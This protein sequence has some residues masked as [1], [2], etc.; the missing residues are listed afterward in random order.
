[1]RIVLAGGGS[2]GST[3]PLLA[4]AEALRR[5]HEDVEFLYIGSET[6]PERALVEK[7]GIRFASIKTGKLRRYWSWQNFLD[8]FRTGIGLMQ[9]FQIIREFQPDALT[10]A[11]GFICVP[12]ALAAWAL[13][14][15]VH[16]HQQDVQ[17]GLANKIISPFA[18]R[19][20]VTFEESKSKFPADKTIL[21]GN[22]VRQEIM[23]G[24]PEVARRLFDLEEGIPTLLATGGGTGAAGLNR[25]IAEAAPRLVDCCQIIHLCGKGKRIATG[26][27]H[28]RYQQVEFVVEEMKDILAVADLVVSRAGLST[29][30]ELGTLCK[31]SILIPMPDSHQKHNAQAFSAVGAAVVLEE[32]QTTPEA[33]AA[34][35]K[36]LI[37]DGL[38]LADMG[39]KARTTVK[40]DAAERIADEV[41]KL[42]TNS[43]F[44]PKAQRD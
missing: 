21:T 13:R 31:P 23:D 34:T 15:P 20:T 40:M 22:P 36:E 12:P 25:L 24:N 39:L 16:I 8:V 37:G 1:M 17:P 28:K 6:G 32:K 2:G 11:G 38:R 44:R 43:P 9:S 27:A 35:V 42:A 30:T 26:F 14:V 5:R 33:L 19:I 3:T 10:S 29:L 18:S 41:I 7:V 4:V